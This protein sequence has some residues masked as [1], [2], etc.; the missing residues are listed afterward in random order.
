MSTENAKEQLFNATINL[1]NEEGSSNKLTART[2]AAKANVNLAMINYYFGSKDS[3][4]KQAVDKIVSERA[5]EL[6][7]IPLEKSPFE[8]LTYLLIQLSDITLQYGDLI[9]SSIPFI[10]LQDEID[11]P[12]YILPYIQEY[13][14]G[15]RSDVECKIIAYQ[16]ISFCQLALYRPD[17]IKKYLNLDIRIKEERD[18][19]IEI[20]LNLHLPPF[21]KGQNPE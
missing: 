20:M 13:F 10:L 6:K 16:L 3:L 19:L 11:H 9:R 2:I 8:K 12:N 1:L 17:D 4:I 21:K 14:Q 18:A 7:K 5:L 15:T